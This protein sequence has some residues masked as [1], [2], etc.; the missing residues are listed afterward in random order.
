[1]AYPGNPGETRVMD[2]PPVVEPEQKH[3]KVPQTGGVPFGAIPPQ[4]MGM[5]PMMMPGMPHPYMIPA[6]L[7][8]MYP[9]SMMPQMMPHPM[10]SPGV[11]PPMGN[12]PQA[13]VGAQVG[14]KAKEGAGM[15]PGGMGA[16]VPMG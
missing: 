7:P 4:P 12:Q 14:G 5:H 6:G 2:A 16:G 10:Y 3:Q 13:K 1:M 11:I 15:P 9:P 8:P